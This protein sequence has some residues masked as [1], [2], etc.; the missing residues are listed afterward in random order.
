MQ[1]PPLVARPGVT[2]I[3]TKFRAPPGYARLVHGNKGSEQ[4]DPCIGSRGDGPG[5]LHDL[6][7]ARR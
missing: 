6:P 4:G 7:N 5:R 2:E 3:D 1:L